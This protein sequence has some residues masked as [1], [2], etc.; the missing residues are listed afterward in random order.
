MFSQYLAVT[1]RIFN[2][3]EEQYPYI[4]KKELLDKGLKNKLVLQ[5]FMDN[6]A[7]SY[8]EAVFR[9]TIQKRWYRI[10]MILFNIINNRGK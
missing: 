6:K 3:N 2:A 10:S 7:N 9:F 5:S 4:I 1:Y 8:K